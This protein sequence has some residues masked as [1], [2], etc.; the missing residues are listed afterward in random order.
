MA[1]TSLVFGVSLVNPAGSSADVFRL[2]F[3]KICSVPMEGMG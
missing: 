3:K 2:A 1:L